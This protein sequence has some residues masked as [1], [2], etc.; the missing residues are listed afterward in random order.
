ML[1]STKIKIVIKKY[2]P[3]SVFG[4][5]KNVNK[6]IFAKARDKFF[7]LRAIKFTK[8]KTV[9][10]VYDDKKFK[11]VINPKNGYLDKQIYVYQKYEDHIVKEIIKASK[12]GDC[13]LDIGAN[14]GHHTLIMSLCVGNSGSVYAFEP[15]PDIRNQLLKSVSIN[16]FKNITVFPYALGDVEKVDYISINE[17]NV[18][19]SSI[20]PAKSMGVTKKIPIEV[21]KL[22]NVTDLTGKVV[23]F[24]KIDVE[25][26]E[27]NVLKGAVNLLK[28][29]LPTIL[30]E[31][32]PLYYKMN[33]SNDAVDIIKMFRGLNYKIY[34]L[35]DDRKEVVND[36]V[37]VQSFSVDGRSQTNLLC[38]ADKK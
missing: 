10:L 31:F 23:S 30:I 6:N 36:D 35:E 13:V 2:L 12:P 33:N 5:V 7:Y 8:E 1:L 4:L 32:S 16:D 14:I 29:D 17:S 15:I 3:D 37:F 19:G 20:V 28:K 9:D 11:I 26:Y 38:I 25:G 21:K 24:I 18:G 22:D 34:D 27:F